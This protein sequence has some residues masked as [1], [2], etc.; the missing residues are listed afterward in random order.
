MFSRYPSGYA[1]VITLAKAECEVK[2]N[3]F[4]TNDNVTRWYERMNIGFKGEVG[5]VEYFDGKRAWMNP[6]SIE[7]AF[8]FWWYLRP[9]TPSNIYVKYALPLTDRPDKEVK[10]MP[11]WYFGMTL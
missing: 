1:D 11:R 6:V 9:S 10:C 4:V 8:R 7:T 3:P 5:A 2:I